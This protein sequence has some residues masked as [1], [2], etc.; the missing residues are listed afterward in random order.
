MQILWR[1]LQN[2]KYV[3]YHYVARGGPSHGHRQHAQNFGENWTCSS[4][5]MIAD[6]QTQTYRQTDT[7][8]TIL[9]ARYRVRSNWLKVKCVGKRKV[10]F[11]VLYGRIFALNYACQR[12]MNNFFR[13]G[14]QHIRSTCLIGMITVNMIAHLCH[15][16]LVA[17]SVSFLSQTSVIFTTNW[18]DNTSEL[19]RST[20]VAYRRHGQALSTARFCH[21]GQITTADT[22]FYSC[23]F[24]LD[25]RPILKDDCR[26]VFVWFSKYFEWCFF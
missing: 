8:I 2:R 24:S 14:G 10:D 21:V 11:C 26:T 5:D 4:G 15:L 22:Y 7:L 6:R 12:D 16:R 1:H 23:R 13:V 18:V 19:R 25:C 9:R 3:I 20:T 17:F